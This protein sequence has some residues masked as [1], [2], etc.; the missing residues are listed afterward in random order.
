MYQAMADHDPNRALAVFNDESVW[1]EPGGNSRGGEFRGPSA[2]AAHITECWKMTDGTLGT[3]I[4]EILGGE[5]FVVAIERTLAL[6]DGRSLNMLVNTVYE[7]SEGVV[8]A[9][10]TLPADC[11]EWNQFWS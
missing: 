9:I 8:T 1:V 5:Q 2:I 7:M 10:R 4:I 11:A 6:R 3:E